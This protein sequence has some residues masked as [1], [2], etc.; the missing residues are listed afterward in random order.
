MS[1]AEANSEAHAF[2][3]AAQANASGGR[4]AAATACAVAGE[5]LV[6]LLAFSS[7]VPFS[8][9]VGCHL[10][11]AALAAGL[12]F[13]PR[14]PE[15]DMTM[16]TV[17]LLLVTVAGPAGALA[18]LAALPFSGNMPVRR[19]ILAD[20]YAR[21]AS[22]GQPTAV[23]KLHDRIGSGRV[24]RFESG[25]PPNYLDVI[26]RGTLEERQRALGL[27]AREF[28]PDYSPVLEAALRSPEPVVRVQAAAV[29][30]RVREDLK[31]RVAALTDGTGT[32]DRS[33]ALKQ[34]G[35]LASISTCPLVDPALQERCRIMLCDRLAAALPRDM[36]V[37]PP[38][39]RSDRAARHAVE[40][41]LIA[42]ARF[43]ELRVMRR[44]AS[45]SAGSK[46]RV[47]R[48]QEAA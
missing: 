34:A 30:A 46:R 14:Q 16:A 3:P 8:A 5:A 42:Q 25:V 35:E 28:H 7:D 33:E 26:K 32:L 29:V 9:V 31:A 20:W 22:A 39:G 27:I 48:R 4:E 41:F 6:V 2:R 13:Y 10:F 45:V 19:D 47:R 1:A 15:R 18:A 43:K 40:T 24:Q 37:L 38:P 21:L 36:R 11:V 17:V 44:L 23:N 12:L